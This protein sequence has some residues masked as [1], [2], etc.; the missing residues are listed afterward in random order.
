MVCST[1]WCMPAMH[2]ASSASDDSMYC[3]WPWEIPGIS[4]RGG[5][6][7]GSLDCDSGWTSGMAETYPTPPT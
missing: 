4:S 7:N 6:S 1:T 2:H 3:T 5:S